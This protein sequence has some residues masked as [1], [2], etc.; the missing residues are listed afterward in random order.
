MGEC[1]GG[2]SLRAFRWRQPGCAPC[3][4]TVWR[5][6]HPCTKKCTHEWGVGALSLEWRA[7]PKT[8]AR[9]IPQWKQGERGDGDAKIIGQRAAVVQQSQHCIETQLKRRSSRCGGYLT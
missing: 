7:D 6:R 4:E 1:I 5:T 9:A 2:A 3:P 8:H